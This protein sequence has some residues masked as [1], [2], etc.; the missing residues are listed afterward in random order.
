MIEQN[1]VQLSITHE[2]L[3][4]AVTSNSLAKPSSFKEPSFVLT[5]V[6]YWKL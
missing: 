3:K 5:Q 6:N 4:V 1:V 2:A